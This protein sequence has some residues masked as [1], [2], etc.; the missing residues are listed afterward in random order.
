MLNNLALNMQA[1]RELDNLVEMQD[2]LPIHTHDRIN[3]KRCRRKWNWQ[4]PLRGHLEQVAGSTDA[5]WF[6]SGFHFALED[7]HGHRRFES[8][9]DA[10]EAY[11]LANRFLDP[12]MGWE[13]MVVQARAMFD[14]Y[15]RYWLPYRNFYDTIWIDGEPLVEVKFRV[16]LP[17][18]SEIAGLP[19]MY[20]GTFDKIVRDK[21]DG[22]VWILDYKTARAMS[23]LNLATDP[24]ISAYCTMAEILLGEPVEGMLYQQHLKTVASPPRKLVRGGYSVDAKQNTSYRLFRNTLLEE[25]GEVPQQYI[26]YLNKLAE[27]EDESGDSYIR[28]YK[29]YRTEYQRRQTLANILAEGVDMLNPEIVL[30]PNPTKDCSWDCP[31]RQACIAMDDDGDVDWLIQDGFKVKGEEPEWR[32][33]IIWP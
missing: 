11:A 13:E 23:M 17:T 2:F 8:P 5:L 19:V 32:S 27:Q 15:V 16:E 1:L 28:C 6:G 22:S 7:Y 25:Y 4:S 26:P 31:F 21:R 10:F 24:Q 30:Y 9:G 3:F 33:R 29:D 20:Q 14:Y 12:P 18:L